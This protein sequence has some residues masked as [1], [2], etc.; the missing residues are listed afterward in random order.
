MEL[1]RDDKIGD[2][3]GRQPAKTFT[4]IGIGLL[5]SLIIIAWV[6]FIKYSI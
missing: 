5:C 4:A 2:P 6:L 3:I 1:E